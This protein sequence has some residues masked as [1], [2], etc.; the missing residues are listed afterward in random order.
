MNKANQRQRKREYIDTHGSI[1][2]RQIQTEL[3]IN[4]ASARIS[5]MVANG[6]PLHKEM[7]YYTKEDGTRSH[8]MKYSWES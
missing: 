6:E 3:N 7:I 5:E 1:T 8:Y 2:I 4:S